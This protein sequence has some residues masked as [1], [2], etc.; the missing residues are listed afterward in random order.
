MGVLFISEEFLKQNTALSENLDPKLVYS[1]VQE[2]QD[3]YIQDV[4]GSKLYNHLKAS[5]SASTITT[6]ETNLLLLIRP[7]LANYTVYIAMPFL[8]LKLKNKGIVKPNTENSETAS[9]SEIKY[10]RE[11][12]KNR[13]EFYVK[14]IQDYLCKN[15]SLFPD[16]TNP[17]NPMW[18][19]QNQG[20]DCPLF[21]DNLNEN[22]ND[23]SGYSDGDL[24]FFR[25]YVR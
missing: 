2:T 20:Y 1:F 25:K 12:Y 10:L 9:L 8:S 15:G 19:N 21:L 5:L 6:D 4:L 16:Y 22:P 7:A 14:R 24:K 23:I 3:M 17:D 11:E 18:P 13:G